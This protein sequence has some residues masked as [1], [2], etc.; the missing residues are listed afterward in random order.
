MD[1]YL[2]RDEAFAHFS[3]PGVGADNID[4]EII[5]RPAGSVLT[6][7]AHRPSRTPAD[8]ADVQP[9]VVNELPTGPATRQVRFNLPVDTDNVSGYLLDGILTVA[10]PVARRSASAASTTVREFEVVDPLAALEESVEVGVENLTK[11]KAQAAKTSGES[12]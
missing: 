8:G 7:R 9:L 2:H 3:L 4:I 10:M 5:S 6:V 12:D 11:T 1:A